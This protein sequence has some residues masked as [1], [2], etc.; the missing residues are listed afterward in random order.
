MADS[1][2][3]RFPRDVQR[4]MKVGGAK[5]VRNYAGRLKDRPKPA[6]AT[7]RVNGTTRRVTRSRTRAS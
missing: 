5:K 3:D 4:L 7:Y 6:E 1:D 2:L